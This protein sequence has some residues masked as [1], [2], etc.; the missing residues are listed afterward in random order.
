MHTTGC[1]GSRGRVYT[2]DTSSIVQTNAAFCFSGMHH[3]RHFHGL[4]AFVQNFAQRFTG[5]RG[6]DPAPLHLNGCYL[7]SLRWESDNSWYG[8]HFT[9]N[10]AK[11]FGVISG[12]ST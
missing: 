4:T 12:N 7:A 11:I 6:H 8:G 9:V 1:D 5:D 3:I 2:A 10:R